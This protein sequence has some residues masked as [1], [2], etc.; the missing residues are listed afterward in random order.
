MKYSELVLILYTAL[1]AVV[2]LAVAWKGYTSSIANVGGGGIIFFIV[3][4]LVMPFIERKVN[5]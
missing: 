3:L 2:T 4:A 5:G 1:V